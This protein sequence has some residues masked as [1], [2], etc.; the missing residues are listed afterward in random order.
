MEYDGIAVKYPVNRPLTGEERL[1]HL[2]VKVDTKAPP[3]EAMCSIWQN[4]Q[5]AEFVDKYYAWKGALCA[6][7]LAPLGGMVWLATTLPAA[8]A[9]GLEKT[10]DSE[11]WMAWTAAAFGVLMFALI[12]G[13]LVWVVLR[14][15]FTLTHF[16]IRFDRKN[17]MVYVFRLR[18]HGDILRVRWDDVYWH[19]RRNR[20]RQFG[21]HNWFLAGHVMAKDQK[22]VL[23]T[24]AFG[25]VGSSPEDLHPLW[26]YVRRFM[27]NGPS[28]VP[29]PTLYLP[30]KSRSER[31]WWGA[32]TIV[33]HAPGSIA[34]ALLLLPI[35]APGAVARW[36]CMRTN[37][38]PV[39]PAD[40][41]T[42]CGADAAQ[43]RTPVRAAQ[44]EYRKLGI[45]LVAGLLIDTAIGAWLYAVVPWTT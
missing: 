9:E 44:P 8:F 21:R 3:S 42:A 11:R 28:A 45:C 26:E 38:L 6:I 36:L 39:W 29:A 14:E 37:R 2:E 30:I 24:F 32:Q 40:I 13:L 34:A 10:P 27:E 15:S 33:L 25:H 4:P 20:N 43:Q 17:R 22:T 1:R 19:I 12:I 16:P 41:D 23:E 31:F 35:T 7:F 18:R 5:C